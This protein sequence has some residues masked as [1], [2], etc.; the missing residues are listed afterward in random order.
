MS[1]FAGRGTPW[2]PA[3]ELT[4][5]KARARVWIQ[6]VTHH[7]S[8]M[9][10][11]LKLATRIFGCPGVDAS[12]R[13]LALLGQKSFIAPRAEIRRPLT[14]GSWTTAAAA[15]A[16]LLLAPIPAG[17]NDGIHREAASRE[18]GGSRNHEAVD[19]SRRSLLTDVATV[20]RVLHGSQD[21]GRGPR[22][23][24][25]PVPVQRASAARAEMRMRDSGP[26]P[27]EQALDVNS[28]TDRVIQAIDRRIVAQ[29]E[30][31]GRP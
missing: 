1:R 22:P 25:A 14:A 7:H 20:R 8:K 11:V 17:R 21:R 24:P 12:P 31:M 28:L 18:N 15:R 3:L 2:G 23:V 5:V 9:H 29:R 13:F 16:P 6:R 10:V 26:R 27:S 4:V 30:R 19:R